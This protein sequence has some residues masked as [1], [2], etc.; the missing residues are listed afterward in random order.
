MKILFLGETYR[1]DAKTWIDGIQKESGLVLDTLEI[2]RTNNRSQRM[3]YAMGFLFKILWMR[4][5]KRYDLVLAERT[6]SYGFFS[7]FVPAKLRVIAQ[8][9]ISDVFPDYGFAGWYK[10]F[11]QR[12]A[13]KDADL[14][15]AWGVVMTYAMVESGANPAKIMIMPKGINLQKFEVKKRATEKRKTPIAIVTRSLYELY[16]HEDIIQAVSILKERKIDMECWI[17]GEGKRKQMLEKLSVELQVADRVRFFGLIENDDLPALLRQSD[18]YL[19][20][21]NTDGVSASLFE[22]MAS[23]CFPIVSDL[24]ANRAFIVSGK[25]GILVPVGDPEK[26]ADAILDYL[27]HEDFYWNAIQKNRAFIEMEVNFEKNM[28]KIFNRYQKLLNCKN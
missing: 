1:A 25:N 22:A 8:Q 4:F 26:L 14:I 7:L 17:V 23:G 20:M 24:P 28:E 2:A 19:S 13:Y 27:T 9:G 11:L 21:P 15:H 5:G 12:W 18:I 10:S 3:I 16:R 6:T